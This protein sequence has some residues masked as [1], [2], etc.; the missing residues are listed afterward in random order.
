MS[1]FLQVGYAVLARDAMAVGAAVERP[2]VKHREFAVGGG[3]NIDFDDVGA[4][5]KA[6]PHRADRILQVS[7]GRRQ[8]PR[9][10]AGVV[11]QVAFV[12]TL[13]HS[14]M[15]EHDRLAFAVGRQKIAVVDVDGRGDDDRRRDVP[16]F[17]A[18]ALPPNVAHSLGSISGQF[19]AVNAAMSERMALRVALGL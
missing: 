15:C 2:V 1:S 9:G 10:R 6:G 7:V 13:R 17:S 14:P 5:L 3:M 12:E 16:D 11:L 18:Q 19:A 8:H 4:G